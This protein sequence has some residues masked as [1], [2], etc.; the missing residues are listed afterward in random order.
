M[1]G[2]HV[3]RSL[4][5]Y[6]LYLS[7]PAESRLPQLLSIYLRMFYLGS[8]TRYN[9]PLFREMLSGRYGAFLR[10]FLSSQPRQF[11]YGIACEFKQQEVSRAA[12]V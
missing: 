9:P 1:E 4:K 11:V 6:Y 7:E 3:N 10:E 12:V 8:V 5:R 2:D